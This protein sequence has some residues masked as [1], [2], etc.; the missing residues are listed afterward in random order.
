MYLTDNFIPTHNSTLLCFLYIAWCIAYKKKRHIVILQNTLQKAKGSLHTIKSEFKDNAQLKKDF[1][2]GIIRD[3]SEDSIFIHPDGFK[4]RVLC[5]GEEQMG[6]IRGEKFGAYR[7]DLILVDDLEDDIMVKSPERR[8]DVQRRFDDAVVPAGEQGKTQY[9][10]VGTILHDDSL[11][12]KLVS[13]NHYLEYKKMFFK[14]LH[15]GKD[16]EDYSLWHE[17]WTVEDLYHL[18]KTKPETFAKEYQGNPVSGSLQKFKQEDFRMW[19]IEEGNYIL[20]NKDCSVKEKGRLSDCRASIGCDMAWEEKKQSDD[21]VVIPIYITPNS[22]ILVSKYFCKKGV[23]P[24][25]FSEVLFNMESSLRRITNH[26]VPIGF[27]KGKIEK[28]NKWFLKQECRRRNHYLIIKDVPWV[29]DKITRIVTPLQPRYAMNSIY[30][31]E[32]MGDLEYQL[33]RIPSG[34]HEDIPDSLQIA[35]RLLEYAP[36]LRKKNHCEEEDPGFAKLLNM[37]REKKSLKSNKKP[38]VF[39]RKRVESGLKAKQS[40]W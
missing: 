5:K 12:A 34:A 19:K 40:L 26:S 7:P 24:D 35:V 9:I 15:R 20:F 18:R 28:I 4:T 6:S 30:H 31:M 21:T 8:I 38:Y 23:R 16:G 2:I 39:G 11:I 27:E 13:P 37:V 33:M 14:A 32:G 29:T 1:K 10:I 36:V 3:S 22:D 25:E 17:R